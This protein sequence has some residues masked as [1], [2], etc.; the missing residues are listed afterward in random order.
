MILK[1]YL[2]ENNINAIKD[3]DFVL[4]YGENIGLKDDLKKINKLFANTELLNLYQEDFNKNKEVLINEYKNNSL[5][6]K[7]KTIIINQTNENLLIDLKYLFENKQS[8]KIIL[9]ADLLEKNQKLDH[10]SKKKKI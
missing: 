4:F 6:A 10:F 8:T 5:F 1:S 2:I 9:F 7:E 3:Y